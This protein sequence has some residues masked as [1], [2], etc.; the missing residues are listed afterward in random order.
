MIRTARVYFDRR[1]T[2]LRPPQHYG[3]VERGAWRQN[4]FSAAESKRYRLPM[5]ITLTFMTAL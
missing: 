5:A 3:P 1:G 4:V 2:H